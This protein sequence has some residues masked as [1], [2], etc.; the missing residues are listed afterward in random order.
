M[1]PIG[2]NILQYRFDYFCVSGELSFFRKFAAVATCII[3]GFY[4]SVVSAELTSSSIFQWCSDYGIYII[5]GKSDKI[6]SN[7]KKNPPPHNVHVTDQHH[8][9]RL[10]GV[11]VDNK[12]GFEEHI[13]KMLIKGSQQ[14][15]LS[16]KFIGLGLICK[17]L[18]YVRNS[19]VWEMFIFCITVWSHF[20]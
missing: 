5:F 4:R 20:S 17:E 3:G 6:F 14:L 9:F 1:R 10:Q 2:T 12:L 18:L 16:I 13:G 7:L 15:F 19:S 11:T 8:H